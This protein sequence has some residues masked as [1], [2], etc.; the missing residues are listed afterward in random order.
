MVNSLLWVRQRDLMGLVR[1][2]EPLR[3]SI[4]ERAKISSKLSRFF[5]WISFAFISFFSKT[6]K[7]D[8]L[9]PGLHPCQRSRL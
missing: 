6:N 5:G 9:R 2:P 3:R 7:P 4:E 1:L 8:S